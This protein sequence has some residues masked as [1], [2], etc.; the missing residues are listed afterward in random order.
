VLV[1]GIQ[2][3]FPADTA[4]LETGDIV[5][6]IDEKP[7]A[8]LEV[9]KAAHAAYVARP[10]PTLFEVLRDRRISLIILKP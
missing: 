3:G 9:I 4:G 6:K 7:L 5:T 1:I 8:S 10:A 2:P